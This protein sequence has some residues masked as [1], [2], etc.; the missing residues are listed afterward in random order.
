MKSSKK[1]KVADI[2]FAEEVDSSEI[3]R[4]VAYQK[5]IGILDWGDPENMI[6]VMVGN[7][8]DPEVVK[9]MNRIKGRPENQVIAVAGFDKLVDKLGDLSQAK[10]LHKNKN[11]SPQE[12]INKLFELPVGLIVPAKENV[13]DWMVHKKGNLRTIMIAGQSFNKSMNYVD[14]FNEVVR[15]LA[16][17]YNTFCAGTS[18]NRSDQDVFTIYQQEKAY[19]ELKTDVDFFV[20][21]K[22]IDNRYKRKKIT[23]C[24][25][26]DLIEERPLLKRWGNKDVGHFKKHLIDLD[27][28]RSIEVLS[29]AEITFQSIIKN[30]L[31]PILRLRL[32]YKKVNEQLFKLRYII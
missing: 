23:S 3:A 6:F 12:I 5:H 17:E 4:R 15:I 30:K 32:L 16:D 31:H 24:T 14:L 21:R 10:A 19:E 1:K 7:G 8:N 9:R 28:P 11:I 27:I 29:G 13:P 22:N 2:Y 26:L 20:M 25:A 18:A